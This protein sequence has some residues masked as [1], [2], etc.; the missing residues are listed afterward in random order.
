MQGS[1]V[2]DHI[3]RHLDRLSPNDR[4][5]ARHLLAHYAEAPFETAE[6]LS[7]KAGVSKAAV[8]RFANRVGYAGYADLHDSLREEAVAR[9]SAPAEHDA[10]R[11]VLEVFVARARADLAR[12]RESIDQESFDEAVRILLVE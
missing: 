6:S 9:L 8:V 7:A 12:T 1:A 3:R 2:S 10:G 11:R 5:I 4:R